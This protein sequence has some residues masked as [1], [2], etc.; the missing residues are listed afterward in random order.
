MTYVK[1]TEEA[2]NALLTKISDLNNR[3]LTIEGMIDEHEDDESY[4]LINEDYI[5][6]AYTLPIEEELSD[7]NEKPKVIFKK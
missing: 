4:S 6:S 5:N 1:I 3:L 2:F 7:I